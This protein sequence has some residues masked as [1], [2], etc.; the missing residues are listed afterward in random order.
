MPAENFWGMAGEPSPLPASWRQPSIEEYAQ[1]VWVVFV[2]DNATNRSVLAGKFRQRGPART[3][4]GNLLR[5]PKK[6]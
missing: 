6:S 3:L 2:R 4:R 1:D 5:I